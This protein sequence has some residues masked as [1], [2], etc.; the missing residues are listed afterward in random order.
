MKPHNSLALGFIICLGLQAINGLRAAAP[1]EAI[2]GQ[3]YPAHR[4]EA[5]GFVNDK[6]EFI[7]DRN[8]N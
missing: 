4:G 5:W 8:S 1:P 3:L 2:L 7:I 6:R